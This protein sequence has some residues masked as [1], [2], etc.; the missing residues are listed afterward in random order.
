MNVKNIISGTFVLVMAYLLLINYRGATSI[1][2]QIGSTYNG[3]VKTLQ[4][5]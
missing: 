2:S 3:A 5:R 4:G 1:I